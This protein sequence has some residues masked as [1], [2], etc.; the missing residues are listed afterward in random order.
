MCL[1][2]LAWLW[3]YWRLAGEYFAKF[4]N[5]RVLRAHLSYIKQAGAPTVPSAVIWLSNEL[6][7]IRCHKGAT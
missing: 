6:K 7:D 4:Q 3:S 1:L 5:L 2:Y